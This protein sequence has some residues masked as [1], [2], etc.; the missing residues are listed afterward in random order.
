MWFAQ[1]SRLQA[2]RSPSFSVLVVRIPNQKTVLITGASVGIG[3][4]L[5]KLFALDGY[6]LVLVARDRVRLADF[7]D[8]LQNQSGITAKSFPLDLTGNSAP[9]FLFDQLARENIAV[10]VLVNNSGYGR[11]GAF[12][13]VAAEE[14]LGQIALN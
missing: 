3:R 2:R 4:E 5:A 9:Q 1:R 11:R 8:E 6:D 7:A 13:E 10:D 14:S 12:S